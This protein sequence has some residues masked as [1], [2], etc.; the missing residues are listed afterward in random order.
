MITPI[1][2]HNAVSGVLKNFTKYKV[3]SN[4][5][6]EDFRAPCFFVSVVINNFTRKSKSTFEVEANVGIEYYPYLDPEKR[7]R[8][9]ISCNK[10]MS[11]LLK[12]FSLN[13]PCGDRFLN[14]TD[15]KFTLGGQNKDLLRMD[16]SLSYF[17]SIR[18]DEVKEE[19]ITEVNLNTKIQMKEGM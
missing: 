9:E 6:L 11:E 1:D 15:G 19:M 10:M 5:V 14:I 3:Y 16:V 12:H 8:D 7:V 2:I 13:L 17:D 4:E 18:P